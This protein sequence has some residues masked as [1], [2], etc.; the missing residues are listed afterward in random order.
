[1][2]QKC[3]CL[4][5]NHHQTKPL[6]TKTY[7]WPA[8]TVQC[9]TAR[10][11]QI[12]GTSMLPVPR[13]RTKLGEASLWA[14][15]MEDITK[16][17]KVL[18]SLL[19][20]LFSFLYIHVKHLK[21]YKLC[22]IDKLAFAFSTYICPMFFQQHTTGIYCRDTGQ[23][24]LILLLLTGE[25]THQL[26]LNKFIWWIISQTGSHLIILTYRTFNSCW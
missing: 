15:F 16:G 7:C 14:T 1:M 26:F 4:Y 2:L 5:I 24:L 6:S 25:M 10:S 11:L 22:Y 9:E 19:W 12:S 20:S 21:V 3:Y 13:I 8:C 23:N 18:D 17:S